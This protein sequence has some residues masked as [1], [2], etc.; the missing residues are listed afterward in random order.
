MGR[1]SKTQVSNDFSSEEE[2][3]DASAAASHQ[4]VDDEEELEAVCWPV[5]VWFSCCIVD[6]NCFGVGRE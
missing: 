2:E 3:E 5:E 1:P 4:I 6:F